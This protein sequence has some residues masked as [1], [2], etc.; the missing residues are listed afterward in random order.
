MAKI[1]RRHPNRWKE[2][3]NPYVRGARDWVMFGETRNPYRDDHPYLIAYVLGFTVALFGS[4][5]DLNG[6][7]RGHM[8]MQCDPDIEPEAARLALCPACI[9]EI[10]ECLTT[11]PRHFDPH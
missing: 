10:H 4:H 5:P 9:D 1:T 11:A 8:C 7:L 6:H 3:R 2:T